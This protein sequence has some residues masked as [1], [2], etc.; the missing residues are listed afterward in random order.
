MPTSLGAMKRDDAV[1]HWANRLGALATETRVPGAT[2][3]ILADGRE[4]VVAHGVLSS[5]TQVSTTTDSLF[6]IGSITKMW[7]AT[8]I[9]QMVD[10]G[11][12]TLDATVSDVLP[13]VP[14]GEVDASSEVTV[15]HL[16]THT[17][18]I[19]GDL[20]T[21]TGRDSDCVE[22][23][24]RM[25]ASAAK[26]HPCGAA[27]SYCNSGFVVLGRIIEV[28]DGG[29]WDTSLRQRMLQPLGLTDTVTL[30]EEAIF[31]RAAVGH[32]DVPRESDPVSTWA[33][34][35]SLGPVGL[36]TASAHDV[37]RFASLHLEG[38]RA[39][40]GTTLLS[41]MSVRTMQ[42][43]QYDIPSV[44]GSGEA[45]G[46]GW[47]L[48]RWDGRR[49]IG[50]DGGTIGQQAYLRMD[51]EARLAVVLLTNSSAADALHQPLFSEVFSEL[52]GITLP[53][54]PAPAAG[55]SSANL[56][57][58]RHVGCYERASRRFDVSWQEGKLTCLMTTTG[59]LAVIN[60]QGVEEVQLFPVDHSGDRFVCRSH[61]GEPWSP[62]IFDR[63][64]DG[65][66]Y[67]YFGGRSTPRRADGTF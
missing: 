35:R 24:V 45:I 60:D 25:L 29:D 3:G 61:D 13:G 17:S 65:T 31:H 22:R 63:F 6:Q 10:E 39:Q 58:H 46:L 55:V 8:M 33:L 57:V 20:F 4:T 66:P 11:R 43:P 23:Y 52:L 1:A 16:L 14:L 28:L 18:G 34:P 19:D 32:R 30:P 56:C 9:M 42:Q 48:E 26:T 54:N 49:V 47:R 21:D 27:Y 5:A 2:L 53:A 38:G 44:G 15:R 59:D 41:L 36:I 62:L 40:D 51:P 64:P 37:L 12:L 7:T 67:L 50:H